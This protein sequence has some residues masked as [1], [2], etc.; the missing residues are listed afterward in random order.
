MTNRPTAPV[1]IKERL[2]SRSWLA[3]IGLNIYSFVEAAMPGTTFDE[4]NLIAHG[5]SVAIFAVG[6]IRDI[7][8]AYIEAKAEAHGVNFEQAEQRAANFD[9]ARVEQ[10]V[11]NIVDGPPPPA[12]VRGTIAP[13]P[14]DLRAPSQATVTPPT[15]TASTVPTGV[16]VHTADPNGDDFSD[17]PENAG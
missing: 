4:N 14:T 6:Y 11:R 15:S 1:P 16:I 3:S 2:T 12:E 17:Q 9:E 8:M 7:A 5:I 10:I 13:T